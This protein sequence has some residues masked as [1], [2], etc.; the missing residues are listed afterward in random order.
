MDFAERGLKRL[1]QA[2]GIAHACKVWEGDIR[3]LDH[4]FELSER[5][6]D[7]ARAEMDGPPQQLFLSVDYSSAASIPIGATLSVLERA[8]KRL[9]AA[10]FVA[11]R[12]CLMPWMLVYDYDAAVEQAEMGLLSLDPTDA[13]DTHY[14]QV[15]PSLP[16]CLQDKLTMNPS[17]AIIALRKMKQTLAPGTA[18]DLVSLLSEMWEYS[19]GR[20]HYWP[21]RLTRKVP[22]LDEYLEECDGIGPGCLLNWYED[23]VLN[24]C[25]DEEVQYIGQNGPLAPTILMSLNLN[26]PEK[27]LDRDARKFFDYIAAMIR[28]LAYAAKI[29]EVVRGL[30]DEHLREHRLKSGLQTEPSAADLR[31]QQL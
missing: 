20:E 12:H 19:R 18:R 16:P 3:L 7:E 31:N 21:S 26:Q 23:D 17:R 10:F 11:F 4:V 13:A 27:R 1:A 30:Y 14:H 24:A 28:S 25:F 22:G 29:V 6:R 2:N 5:E 8:D 9:P 15:A